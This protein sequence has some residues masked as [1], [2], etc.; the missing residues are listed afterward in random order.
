MEGSNTYQDEFS[1]NPSSGHPG[2]E[3]ERQKNLGM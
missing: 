1:E 3:K 2:F